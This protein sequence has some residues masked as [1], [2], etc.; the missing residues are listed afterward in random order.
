MCDIFAFSPGKPPLGTLPASCIPVTVLG[1]SL[2]FP[3]VPEG[4][5]VGLTL[6]YHERDGY[7]VQGGQD[8]DGH[9]QMEEPCGT[10]SEQHNRT[11]ADHESSEFRSPGVIARKRG[12]FPACYQGGQHTAGEHGEKPGEFTAD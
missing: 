3:G 4:G 8:T 5:D 9:S 7:L 12:E 2:G 1:A 6:G 10:A 11:A